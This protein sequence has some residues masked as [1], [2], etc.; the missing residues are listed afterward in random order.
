MSHC[1]TPLYWDFLKFMIL[2][3]LYGG[4]R[5]CLSAALCK[6]SRLLGS[7]SLKGGCNLGSYFGF[8]IHD[9]EFEFLG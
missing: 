2:R 7:N 9:L 4:H 3:S 6:L 1:C 8:R 5:A